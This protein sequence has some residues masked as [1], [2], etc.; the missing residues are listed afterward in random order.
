LS[1]YL[2]L[3]DV[4]SSVDLDVAGERGFARICREID[5]G[6][7]VLLLAGLAP[8][9]HY[10]T[11]IGYI[12]DEHALIC[13]D[14]AGDR[15]LGYPNWRGAAVTYDWPGWNHGRQNLTA[16]P[17]IIYAR[18]EP[19]AVASTSRL[20]NVSTRAWCGTESAAVIA[21]FVVSSGDPKRILVRAVGPTL[22]NVG[23]TG[24]ILRD[25]VLEVHRAGSGDTLAGI[26]LGLFVLGRRQILV[27]GVVYGIFLSVT[28]L[29]S[30]FQGTPGNLPGFLVLTLLLSVVGAVAGVVTVFI[31][32]WLRA[33]FR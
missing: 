21:G 25:P 22:A 6:H 15:S 27:V 33:R 14:P 12:T 30:G 26:V 20:V 16:V 19:I 9:G 18:A 5:A 7:P 23:V 3:H 17:R 24:D 28:F 4:N 2:A 29:L 32:S 11:C 10:L 8:S 31:G 13:H 1:E